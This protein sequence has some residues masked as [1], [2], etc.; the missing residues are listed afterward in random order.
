M[1]K[2]FI[3]IPIFLYL[4]LSVN[5]TTCAPKAI[6]KKED[7]LK[8]SNQEQASTKQQE[9]QRKVEIVTE[10]AKKALKQVTNSSDDDAFLVD[11]LCPMAMEEIQS[12]HD[13]NATLQKKL[14][15]SYTT[16]YAEHLKN[17]ELSNIATSVSCPDF[18]ERLNLI[19]TAKGTITKPVA[20]TLKEI[21]EQIKNVSKNLTPSEK[22]DLR[23]TDPTISKPA[24]TKFTN[25]LMAKLMMAEISKSNTKKVLS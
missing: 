21:Q 19:E 2:K 23:S 17:P 7:I 8:P 20:P 16:K 22:N 11:I 18:S 1:K 3:G 6:P 13:G 4:L 15:D 24:L 5:I 9:H 10:A 14:Q 12:I 25:S